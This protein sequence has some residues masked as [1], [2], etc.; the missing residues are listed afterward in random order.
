M[1]E[2]SH[3]VET[4]HDHAAWQPVASAANLEKTIQVQGECWTLRHEIIWRP[5]ENKA[6]F[7]DRH[8]MQVLDA[9]DQYDTRQTF[10]YPDRQ[11]VCLKGIAHEGGRLSFEVPGL[12]RRW[13]VLLIAPQLLRAKQPDLRIWAGDRCVGVARHFDFVDR[14]VPWR[15]LIIRLRAQDWNNP[16]IVQM[17]PIDAG[18]DHSFFGCRFYLPMTPSDAP[19][20]PGGP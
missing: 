10:H 15:N 19:P 6:S 17:E 1:A 12:R 4:L 11:K 9:R 16:Q 3:A 5:H 14:R 8:G 13:P 2:P 20:T 18:K 7:F